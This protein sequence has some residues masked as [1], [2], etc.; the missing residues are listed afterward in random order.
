MAGHKCN[1]CPGCPTANYVTNWVF[2][3][4]PKQDDFGAFSYNSQTKT[5][6]FDEQSFRVT[7]DCNNAGKWKI[8]SY[9]LDGEVDWV[10]T[11]PPRVVPEY[12]S[13]LG[14]PERF[15]V[16]N[17]TVEPEYAELQGAHYRWIFTGGNLTSFLSS[18]QCP[19]VTMV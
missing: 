16:I 15:Y 5:V 14:G 10:A 3:F 7:L 11:S 4:G 9:K 1:N 18:M 8:T 2:V 12:L 6:L 19:E 13:G 17:W